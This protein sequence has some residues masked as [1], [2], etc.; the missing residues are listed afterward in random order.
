[1]KRKICVALIAALTA[2]AFAGCSGKGKGSS[3]S[4]ETT[5]ETAGS[6]ETGTDASEAGRLRPD[7][8]PVQI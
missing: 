2:A 5:V 6:Q 8:S 1:M 4:G 3:Q 7:P